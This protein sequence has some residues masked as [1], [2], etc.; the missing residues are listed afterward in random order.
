MP[1]TTPHSSR[2]RRVLSS[3]GA[4]LGALAIAGLGP[5]ACAA[6]QHVTEAPPHP[7]AVQIRNNSAGASVLT[8]F[9][10]RDRGDMRQMLG[11]VPGGRTETFKYK[12]VAWDITYRLLATSGSQPGLGEDCRTCIAT[13]PPFNVNDPNT[14]GVVWDLNAN[15]VQFYDLPEQQQVPA[16]DTTKTAPLPHS[17][18]VP[19]SDLT[20]Q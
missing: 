15:Q 19:G 8:V 13:S 12:P 14:G 3:H 1:S 4:I 11:T 16:T 17:S 9:I 5:L 10:S 7:I 18:R 6:H 20:A 2:R